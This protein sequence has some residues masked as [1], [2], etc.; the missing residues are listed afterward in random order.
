MARVSLK[1]SIVRFVDG[2]S[3]SAT[4]DD[5]PADNDTTLTIADLDEGTIIPISS[6]FTVVGNDKLHTITAQNANAKYVLTVDATSGNFTITFDGED[7]ENLNQTTG[8]IAEDASASTVQT[9]LEGLTDI[10]PGDV[11]VTGSNGG[12][13][14][15]EF[16]GQYLG[17]KMADL[18]ATDVDLMGGGDTVGV[19]TTYEGGTTHDLTFTP[20]IET[21]DGVPSN[22]A[23]ITFSG[24]TLEI[25]VGDGNLTYEETREFDY[26]LDRG[27][28]DDVQEGDEQPVQVNLDM[29]WEA[30]RALDGATTPTPE[31]VL[32]NTGAAADWESYDT[33]TCKPYSIGIE[34]ET[35]KAG[36]P[37]GFVE[38]I[39]L[40]NYRWESLPHDLSEATVVT[41]GRCNVT[42]ATVVRE[43]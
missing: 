7:G 20:A 24:R 6:R 33:D 8:N 35:R 28:L 2:F 32:K 39:T 25:K 19:V 38:R 22:N 9:A 34:V 14:T 26:V 23:V 41:S 43:I 21:E 31:E 29:V 17:L 5:S 1:R 3:A 37:D 11:V 18:A 42:Q 13:W 40:P 4:V 12:P 10:V 30:L 36:C 15:I 27:S 16:Q